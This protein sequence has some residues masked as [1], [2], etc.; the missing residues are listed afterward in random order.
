MDLSVILCTYNRAHSLPRALASVAAQKFARA[1]EWEVLV[2]DNNSSDATRE[3]IEQFC[4]Q[5]PNRFRYLFEPAQGK[6]YALNTGVRESRGEILAFTDDDVTCEPTWLE[7]LTQSL[8]QGQRAGAGGRIRLDWAV[9]TPHWLRTNGHNILEEVLAGFDCGDAQ[10]E[11]AFAPF[12]ANMAFRR[13][14]FTRYGGFRTDLGPNT[15][16]LIRS[17]DTEFGRRLMAGGERLCYEPE[18]VVYHDVPEKRTK[19]NYFQAW[20][21]DY[22]RAIVRE[23]GIPSEAICYCGVPRYLFR[24]LVSWTLEWLV[25]FQP[26]MRFYRKLRVW[27]KAGEIAESYQLSNPLGRGRVPQAGTES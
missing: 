16:N 20:Y 18:A 15:G 27:Q 1:V 19:K 8:R 24:H 7:N 22:G 17:E 23:S 21:Y 26:Y 5:Y 4:R 11:L 12:G 2:V 13:E 25:T 3:V 14:M 6:S 9:T 10:T